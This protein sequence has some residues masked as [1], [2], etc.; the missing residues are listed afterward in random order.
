MHTVRKTG[1]EDL[2][3]LRTEDISLSAFLRY[4]ILLRLFFGS[5]LPAAEN[6]LR[7]DEF[8]ERNRILYG[9]MLKYREELSGILSQ[10]ED[11]LYI[12]L[13]VLFGEKVDKA[14]LDWAQEAAGI[15]GKKAQASGGAI[16]DM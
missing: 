15:L 1:P 2:N 9:T 13:T 10:S 11:H 12:Y 7:I 14:Y 3:K 8:F 5:L 16:Q 4:E 6:I